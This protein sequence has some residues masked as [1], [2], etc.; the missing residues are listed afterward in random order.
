MSL[1]MTAHLIVYIDLMAVQLTKWKAY[2]ICTKSEFF[3]LVMKIHINVIAQK[4][5][6]HIFIFQYKSRPGLFAF[7][8][9]D[10]Q[11]EYWLHTIPYILI[12]IYPVILFQDWPL[13]KYWLHTIPYILIIIYPAGSL[14][15]LALTQVL[16]THTIPYILIIIIPLYYVALILLWSSMGSILSK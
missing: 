6:I 11:L 15:R 10:G 9:Q 14:S 2:E 5:L 7:N 8:I 13:F 4:S 3:M 16:A 1:M 12:I